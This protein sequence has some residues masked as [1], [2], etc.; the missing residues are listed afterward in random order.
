MQRFT[1]EISFLL[2]T[3]INFIFEFKVNILYSH[4]EKAILHLQEKKINIY[5]SG[6]KRPQSSSEETV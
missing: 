1:T 6:R 2:F 4:C 5:S 3:R